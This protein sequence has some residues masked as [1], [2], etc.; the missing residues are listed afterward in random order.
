MIELT[1][2]AVDDTYRHG[3][4]DLIAHAPR[5]VTEVRQRRVPVLVAAGGVAIP[6]AALALAAIVIIAGHAQRSVS[7]ANAVVKAAPL[8]NTIGIGATLVPATKVTV[9]KVVFIPAASSPKEAPAYGL[10]AVVDVELLQQTGGVP[11]QRNAQEAAALSAFAAQL[12]LAQVDNDVARATA[13]K[14]IIAIDQI[15]LSRDTLALMP[16]SFEYVASDGESYAA[17][18]GNSAEAD[19]SSIAVPD[20]SVPDLTSIEVVFDVR[21]SGG[22]IQLTNSQGRVVGRWQAP[23]A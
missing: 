19:L 7:P 16:F 4:A 6:L 18:D 13:L 14:S 22:V 9:E 11:P 3:I 15:Q 2:R 23:T 10:Y 17:W 20:F 1:D 12:Q 21:S 5:P 8:G